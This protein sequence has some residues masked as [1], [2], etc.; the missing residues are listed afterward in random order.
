MY[1]FTIYIEIEAQDATYSVWLSLA[2][3]RSPA[4]AADR[5]RL[6]TRTT[7]TCAGANYNS[8]HKYSA[9]KEL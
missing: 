4:L 2:L 1:R 3:I 6:L 9:S 8:S 7:V 5:E